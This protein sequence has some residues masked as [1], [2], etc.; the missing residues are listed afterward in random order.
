MEK[1]RGLPLPPSLLPPFSPFSSSFCRTA[2][3]QRPHPIYFFRP[4]SKPIFPNDLCRR[5][6]PNC[7]RNW[8]ACYGVPF[9][10]NTCTHEHCSTPVRYSLSET[11][12]SARGGCTLKSGAGG[13][14]I[15]S[16]HR[17]CGA[18]AIGRAGQRASFLMRNGD[19]PKSSASQVRNGAVFIRNQ[20]QS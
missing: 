9:R 1:E 19:A 18:I 11:S 16:L 6:M 17:S 3:E 10:C 5:H 14:R 12:R 13:H 15:Y 2:R 7:E 4:P 20:R 8:P